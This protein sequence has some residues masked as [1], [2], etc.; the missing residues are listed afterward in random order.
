MFSAGQFINVDLITAILLASTAHKDN[1]ESYC[2]TAGFVYLYFF[3]EINSTKITALIKQFDSQIHKQFVDLIIS[4]GSK[5]ISTQDI[6]ILIKQAIIN[7]GLNFSLIEQKLHLP[8]IDKTFLR[9]RWKSYN[10]KIDKTFSN[11]ISLFHNLLNE[12]INSLISSL[13]YYKFSNRSIIISI[14]TLSNYYPYKAF[15]YA[16]VFMQISGVLRLSKDDLYYL[17][18]FQPFN[19]S[20][21]FVQYLM[22]MNFFSKSDLCYFNSDQ[23]VSAWS[24]QPK[25]QQHSIEDESKKREKIILMREIQNQWEEKIN[26]LETE[27]QKRFNDMDQEINLLTQ[28]KND[29][30]NLIN[31]ANNKISAL[32]GFLLLK[33]EQIV[34]FQADNIKLKEDIETLLVKI[35]DLREELTKR[36]TPSISNINSLTHYILRKDIVKQHY[37]LLASILYKYTTRNATD[38]YLYKVGTC[39]Y[40]LGSSCYQWLAKQLP[41][42]D[43][44]TIR[45]HNKVTKEELRSCLLNIDGINKTIVTFYGDNLPKMIT[46]GGDGAS[47]K[48]VGE[49]AKSNIYAFEVLPLEH[50]FKPCVVHLEVIGGGAAPKSIRD[51]YKR[52]GEELRKLSIITKFMATDGDVSFDSIHDTWFNKFIKGATFNEV[53]NSMK[54]EEFIPISDFLHLLKCARSH[55]LNHLTMLLPDLLICLNMNL[56]QENTDLG[57]ALTDKTSYGRMKDAYAIAIF[58]WDTYFSLLKAGR[59]DACYYIY[60]FT[61]MGTAIRSKSINKADRLA[62]LEAAFNIFVN[63][64]NIVEDNEKNI[65]FPPEY[66]SGALGTLFGDKHFLHRLINTCAG[67]AVGIE[68]DVDCL[69]TQRI[70]THDL[71]CF[72]GYMRLA[73]SFNHTVEEAIRS[74]I[75]SILLNTYAKAINQPIHIRTRD[76][77]GGVVLDNEMEAFKPLDI[78]WLRIYDI[79]ESLLAAKQVDESSMQYISKMSI[80]IIERF[81]IKHISLPS[82]FA[83]YGPMDRNIRYKK[84]IASLPISLPGFNTPLDFFT[85]RSKVSELIATNAFKN[86]TITVL[87]KVLRIENEQKDNPQQATKQNREF[88]FRQMVN[89]EYKRVVDAVNKL[90]NTSVPNQMIEGFTPSYGP[91]LPA[92]PT[93]IDLLNILTSGQ[94]Q[95]L[96]VCLNKY[97][98]SCE[99]DLQPSLKDLNE[100]YKKQLQE[101]KE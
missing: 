55:I 26:R 67:I 70:S 61:L 1:K 25:L 13:N 10:V 85:G 23:I 9:D 17:Y 90:C 14:L 86:W 47:I 78:N 62:L 52:I 24:F 38:E 96:A 97:V 76:N 31:E 77:V 34:S 18:K 56:M 87:Q 89:N 19:G 53:L 3:S 68:L 80:R 79:I 8:L 6:D 5:T 58:S 42:Y 46:L 94:A 99:E 49:S 33:E 35:K 50:K 29:L 69:A 60:P 98:E 66:R 91:C 11:I 59:Y 72:F 64:L 37:P 57:E 71:E 45:K 16:N 4:N 101:D 30:L 92:A 73:A 81:E 82:I 12:N 83:G 28:Q 100:F 74:C 75:N 36:S 20:T 21:L 54:N 15:S 63:I 95:E 43:E 22:C 41:L 65:L 44:S 27:Y 2:I 88:Q 93:N 40:I 7:Y 39:A 84:R 32:K 51:C 48:P